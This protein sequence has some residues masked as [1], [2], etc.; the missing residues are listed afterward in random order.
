MYISTSLTLFN[1]DINYF[2][3]VKKYVYK[4]IYFSYTCNILL[5]YWHR[6]YSDFSHLTCV[7]LYVMAAKRLIKCPFVMQSI[8]DDLPQPVIELARAIKKFGVDFAGH[9]S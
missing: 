5:Q 8:M 1:I 9:S 3:L 6:Y 2:L 7:I 4:I